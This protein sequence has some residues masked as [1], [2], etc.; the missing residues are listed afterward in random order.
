LNAERL[1]LR[2]PSAAFPPSSPKTHVP[3]AR[4]RLKT[5]PETAFYLQTVDFVLVEQESAD[6]T[7]SPA[8]AG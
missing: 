2:R 4:H 3:P 8:A 7:Q 6:K 5:T 1:G